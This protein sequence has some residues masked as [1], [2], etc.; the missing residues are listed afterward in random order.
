MLQM[1]PQLLP[2]QAELR[3][4][5]LEGWFAQVCLQGGEQGVL[6][7]CQSLEQ[8]LQGAPAGGEGQ[9]GAGAEIGPLAGGGIGQIQHDSSLS[10]VTGWPGPSASWGGPWP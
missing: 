7:V 6:P 5:A 1:E 3:H 4:I 10:P 8:T 2:H 9:G